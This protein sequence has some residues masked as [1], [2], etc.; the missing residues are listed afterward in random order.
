MRDLIKQLETI[1][2][3]YRNRTIDI[4]AEREAR[5][6]ARVHQALAAVREQTGSRIGK[7]GLV[8]LHGF[9]FPSFLPKSARWVIRPAGALAG[10]FLIALGGWVVAGSV[11]VGVLPGDSLYGVKLASERAHA[12]FTFNPKSKA[13]LELEFAARRLDEANRIAE[14]DFPDQEDR[15]AVAMKQFTSQ[16]NATQTQLRTL[17]ET[18]QPEAVAVAKIVDRKVAEYQAALAQRKE[19]ATEAA[20]AQV[21]E[22]RE[23]VEDTS[24]VAV[25]VLLEGEKGQV[26]LEVQKRVGE[27]L[28]ELEAQIQDVEH[29]LAVIPNGNY[30]EIDKIKG[31]TLENL[32][33]EAAKAR[34]ILNDG[35]DLFARG[36]FEAALLKYREGVGSLNQLHWGVGLYEALIAELNAKAQEAPKAS[37]ENEGVGE[38]PIP[39]P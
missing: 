15:L 5:M 6:D 22:A 14:N 4:S 29:R 28:Q 31:P 16:M 8:F 35:K 26:S 11:F 9:S 38:Q 30:P 21:R 19:G 3:A 23:A 27:R 10:I 25:T 17:K 1:G 39:S 20:Q 37:E 13:Q 24:F 33:A 32:R 36:G 7:L 12:S 2:A 18:D 34:E